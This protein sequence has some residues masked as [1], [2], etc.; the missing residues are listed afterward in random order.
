MKYICA[1]IGC[2]LALPPQAAL[3]N[4]AGQLL[5]NEKCTVCH[6][7]DSQKMG[8]AVKDMNKEPAALR[9]AITEGVDNAGP[10][11]MPA[12]GEVLKPAEIDALMTYI[13]GQQ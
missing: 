2:C 4:D 7:L 13:S 12:F 6:A 5:F 10:F 3:A 8:P 9:G 11:P 1:M